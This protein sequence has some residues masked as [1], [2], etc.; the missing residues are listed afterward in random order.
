[1]TKRFLA[2]TLALCLALA[3]AGCGEEAQPPT[4][5]SSIEVQPSQPEET[6]PSA[7]KTQPSAPEEPE[8]PAADPDEA[9]KVLTGA[10]LKDALLV[11]A[12]DGWHGEEDLLDPFTF[13]IDAALTQGHPYREWFPVEEGSLYCY[14]KEAVRQMVWE[15]FGVRDWEPEGNFSPL[16]WNERAQRWQSTLECGLRWA[17]FQADV[18]EM[19]AAWA[20]EDTLTVSFPLWVEGEVYGEPGFL[21]LGDAVFTYRRMEEDGRTFLRFTAM[22]VEKYKTFRYDTVPGVTVPEGPVG[23]IRY[24]SDSVGSDIAIEEPDTIAAILNLLAQIKVYDAPDEPDEQ[25]RPFGFTSYQFF[26]APEDEDPAFTVYLNPFC[27]EA[28]GE[29]SGCYLVDENSYSAVNSFSLSR[30]MYAEI[31]TVDL[32]RPHEGKR[33]FQF[34]FRDADGSRRTISFHLPENWRAD[35]SAAAGPNGE[36]LTIAA[37][38]PGSSQWVSPGEGDSEY[39]GISY[40]V[41]SLEDGWQAT[42]AEKGHFYRLVYSQGGGASLDRE[43]FRDLLRDLVYF[44]QE[45]GPDQ[46]A[47]VVLEEQAVIQ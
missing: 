21:P 29:R 34:P 30:Q 45:R 2:L 12:A 14:P 47:Q 8:P 3:L 4:Q 15:V 16:E 5:P 44:I 41:V 23:K 33:L 32:K 25:T 27:V 37:Y 20:D 39:T 1:M 38:R 9:A 43:G 26:A 22:E 36:R 24:R 35:G 40:H 7:I 18:E 31:N 13:F 28:G 11:G 42:F 10:I 17:S 19:T 46:M 6:P